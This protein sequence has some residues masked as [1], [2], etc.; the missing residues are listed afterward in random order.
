MTLP[1]PDGAA[2]GRVPAAPPEGADAGDG[3]TPPA[4][5]GVDATAW[6]TALQACAD[7]APTRPS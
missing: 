5:P 1:Q 3:G 2:A 6:D 4:P 7:L